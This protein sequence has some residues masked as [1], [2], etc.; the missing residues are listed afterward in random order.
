MADPIRV[1]LIAEACNPTW[2]SVPLVGYNLA[3][4]LAAR[5]DLKVTLVTH[6]R[7]RDGI[8]TSDIGKF[9]EIA[10]IDNEFIVRPVYNLAR[11]IRGGPKQKSGDFRYGNLGIASQSRGSRRRSAPPVVN[12][13]IC[14]RRPDDDVINNVRPD[15]D[16]QAAEPEQD[17]AEGTDEHSDQE[18]RGDERIGLNE[19][20]C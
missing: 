1:L 14:L 9:A 15:R 10:Y 8:V 5:P 18:D 11:L 3:R 12:E 16:A 17:G 20:M 13:K 6:V 4:A 7:N 19:V 2:T